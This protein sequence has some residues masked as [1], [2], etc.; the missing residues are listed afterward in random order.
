MVVPVGEEVEEP[1]NSLDRS[2]RIFHWE[3]VVKSP[4]SLLK[5]AL[6]P[7][8]VIPY[9]KRPLDII[10]SKILEGVLVP[11]RVIRD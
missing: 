9:S 6:P 2:R 4:C 8:D 3:V 7:L 11:R 10:H 1:S 5:R